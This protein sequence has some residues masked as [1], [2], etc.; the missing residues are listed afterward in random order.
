MVDGSLAGLTGHGESGVEVLVLPDHAVHSLFNETVRHST[1]VPLYN[2]HHQAAGF[3]AS[4]GTSNIMYIST[5]HTTRNS[6]NFPIKKCSRMEIRKA[7]LL[8][9]SNITLIIVINN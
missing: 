6:E 3:S 4:T 1:V 2:L 5:I 7:K 8:E 9:V